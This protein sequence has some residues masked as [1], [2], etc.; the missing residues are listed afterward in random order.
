MLWRMTVWVGVDVGGKRKGFDVAV[1]DDR[2]VLVLRGHLTCR[3]V[4]DVVLE[5]RPAVVA[6]DSPRSCAPAGQTARDGELKLARSICGIR[7][8]PDTGRVHASAYYAWILEGLDL[9]DTL[10]DRGAEV[11]E[12]FPTASWTRWHGKRGSQSRAAWSRQGLAALGLENVPART[13]QDQRDAIAAA[14]TARQHS[15]ALTETIGEIV[16]PAGR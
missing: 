13:N 2:R 11:I 8:T 3:Q 6:I 7:W 5:K 12:V 9:F 16:V 15:L 1:I 14:M 4:V 10:A